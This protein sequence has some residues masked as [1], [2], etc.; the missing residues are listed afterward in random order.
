MSSRE[1][2]P[3][4]PLRRFRSPAMTSDLWPCLGWPSVASLRGLSDA[5]RQGQVV[6]RS[7]SRWLSSRCLLRA[8]T[9][10]R[11]GGRGTHAWHSSCHWN[12]ET[13]K[14][15]VDIGAECLHRRSYQSGTDWYG[16]R[17]TGFRDFVQTG[18]A[19]DW[20]RLPFHGS[21]MIGAKPS[22]SGHTSISQAS[23]QLLQRDDTSID[24]LVSTRSI[25]VNIIIIHMIIC[26][27]HLHL[28]FILVIDI[29]NRCIG[30]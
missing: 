30:T 26:A 24:E 23:R 20:N 1:P 7:R 22:T 8:L 9:N 5:N 16:E 21:S 29:V 14:A 27:P 19:L 25:S 15:T 28:G 13:S 18:S 4:A 6:S 3:L 17:C 10:S 12:A 2:C 11:H